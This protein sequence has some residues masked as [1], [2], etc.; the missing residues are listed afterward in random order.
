MCV[1][2]YVCLYVHLSIYVHVQTACVPASASMLPLFTMVYHAHHCGTHVRLPYICLRVCLHIFLWACY[3]CSLLSLYLSFEVVVRIRCVI[4][5]ICIGLWTTSSPDDH[6]R[7]ALYCKSAC[8]WYPIHCCCWGR[9]GRRYWS[10]GYPPSATA[11]YPISS[12]CGDY[13]PPKGGL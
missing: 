10:G 4:F 1:C 7:S 11:T 3:M 12:K 5:E 9:C 8:G 13:A 6:S 2:T